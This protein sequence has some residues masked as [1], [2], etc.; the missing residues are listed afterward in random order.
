MNELFCVCNTY[1]YENTSGWARLFILFCQ[2]FGTLFDDFSKLLQNPKSRFRIPNRCVARKS[3]KSTFKAGIRCETKITIR[4]FLMFYKSIFH[5]P[6]CGI[7]PRE[8]LWKRICWTL[9]INEWHFLFHKKKCFCFQ[10]ICKC[11][12]PW[13]LTSDA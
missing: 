11:W 9:K 2:I 5:N 1:V 13:T 4:L 8:G 10:N 12:S 3:I 6:A 7:V